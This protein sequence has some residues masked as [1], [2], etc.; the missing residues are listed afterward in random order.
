MKNV[1]NMLIGFVVSAVL[2]GIIV[3]CGGGS[4]GGDSA[5]PTYTVG[6]NITGA[7][8]TVV[9]KLN[10]GND[11]SMA[12]AGAFTF[13]TG[14]VAG[15]T[16]NVQVAAPNQRCTVTSGAGTMGAAN[17]SNVAI[18][19]GAQTTQMVIRSTVLTG[20]LQNPPVTTSA[21]GVGGVIVDPT[22]TDVN[23]NV[24]ITGGITFSGLSGPP[25]AGGHHIHQTLPGDPTGNGNVI[26]GL[27]L[28]SDGATAYVPTNTRL[29]P[30][31]YTALLAGE[32]YFNVHTVANSGG[33]I[34]GQITAQGGVLAA[35]AN[36]T[37]A[38]EVSAVG[39]PDST[40]TATGTGTLLADAATHTILISYITHNV[41][42]TTL[43]G[44]HIHTS[45]SVNPPCA[46]GPTC[47]GAVTI[48]F[49]QALGGN[50]AFSPANA[51]MST[52]D[53]SS[54]FSSYLYFNV[55]STNN[56]C[57]SAGNTSCSGGE[58][59]GNITPIP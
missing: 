48:G 34:R 22:N 13:P 45:V 42:N 2:V 23:G 59:R 3:S 28:A 29:T 37:G 56:L 4:G 39:A 58:I 49:N 16:Y 46:G 44:A 18:T 1:R 55:H 40:S 25:T 15:S 9:L 26:I 19:C 51:P 33:E 35:V 8:G 27:T 41:T 47:K 53:V 5:V 21:T 6:G 7:A 32:L 10:G 43:N 14:L 54:F 11:M 31:Q 24:L 30:A 38:Q 12:A 57:G 17:I 20:A 50:I 36:L 52:S